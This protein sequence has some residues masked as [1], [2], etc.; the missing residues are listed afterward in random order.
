MGRR[1]QESVSGWLRKAH[2]GMGAVI[3]PVNVT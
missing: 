1:N 2:P 3:P